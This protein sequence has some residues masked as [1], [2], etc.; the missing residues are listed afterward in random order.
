MT[1]AAK[2]WS[3]FRKPASFSSAAYLSRASGAPAR[4]TKRELARSILF[5]AHRDLREKFPRRSNFATYKNQRWELDVADFGTK[6]PPAL[7]GQQRLPG[8]RPHLQMLVAVDVFSRAIYA[9][10][11][12]SRRGPDMVDA[13]EKIFRVAHAKPGTIVSDKGENWNN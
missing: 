8:R 3:Q 6:I 9:E 10:A 1:D 13:L 5:Q 2:R 4:Q 12:P 11:I 7:T